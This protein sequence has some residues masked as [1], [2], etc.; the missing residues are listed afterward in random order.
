VRQ[1]HQKYASHPKPK[2]LIGEHDAAVI[3]NMVS[4]FRPDHVTDLGLGPGTAT[5]IGAMA[6][7][8]N[9]KGKVTGLEQLDWMARLAEELM[10]HE[11]PHRV[12]IELRTP[13]VRRYY[14]K[15][16]MCYQFT[17]S[18]TDIDMVIVEVPGEWIDNNGNLIRKPCV[19]LVEPPT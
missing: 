16:R 17:P 14:G 15:E 11:L 6:M 10:P 19:D 1:L 4:R 7:E 18:T 12:T 5:A 3:Y 2:Y 8:S 9:C 13:E